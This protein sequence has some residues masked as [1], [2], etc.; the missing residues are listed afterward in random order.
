MTLPTDFQFSQSS[1]Q[2]YQTCP[3]RFQLRYLRQQAWPAIESE[4][5]EEAERLTDLG[6]QFHRLVHRHL[7]GL[8][9]LIPLEPA[10]GEPE[11]AEWWANYLAHRPDVAGAELY[12]ELAISAELRGHRLAARFDLLARRP[13]GT[14][15]LVD[16][17]TARRKPPRG[18]LAQRWQTRVYP[19]LLVAG[20]SAYSG[21]NPID[22]AGV[23]MLYWYP[24]FPTEPEEFAYSRPLFERDGALLSDLIER[25]KQAAAHDDFPA[26]DHL[27]DCRYCVYRSWCERGEEAGAVA[28][29]L[30][31][32]E[33]ADDPLSLDWEQIAELQF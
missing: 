26:T 8:D 28:A 5:V 31:A 9:E 18:Y 13:D 2:D 11:L 16:W 15:L 25:V 10:A 12:P 29:Q 30:D 23:T 14:F 20:G 4:P 1:L 6:A 7:L 22:P 3:R 27:P 24:Q 33:P 21:G 19:W 32:P 17:K